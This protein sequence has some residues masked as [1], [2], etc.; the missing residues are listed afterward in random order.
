MDD[1][2]ADVLPRFPMLRQPPVAASHMATRDSHS[3]TRPLRRSSNTAGDTK[4]LQKTL[5]RD[6]RAQVLLQLY[7]SREEDVH[8]SRYISTSHVTSRQALRGLTQN[9]YRTRRERTDHV[10]R[11]RCKV[12][13]P[14]L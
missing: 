2:F 14:R 3:F 5:Q 8:S 12:K 10:Q 9:E 1:L 4:F 13:C 7:P 11:I 6:L